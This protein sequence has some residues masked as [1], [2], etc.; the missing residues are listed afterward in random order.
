MEIDLARAK[1]LS[2]EA[3]LNTINQPAPE[4]SVQALK[5]LSE[6]KMEELDVDKEQ[7]APIVISWED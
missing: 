1:A 6:H 7:I 2:L 3:T 5:F 4:I